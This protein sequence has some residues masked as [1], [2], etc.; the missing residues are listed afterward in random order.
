[1]DIYALGLILAELLHICR[2]FSETLKLFECLK[3]G[4]LDVFNYKEK[5]LLRKLLSND[6]KKRPNA[7]EILK[8]LKEWKNVTEKKKRN[9]C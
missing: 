3:A 4:V 7:S 5:G 1:M 8:T 6:P 9:T 2:T